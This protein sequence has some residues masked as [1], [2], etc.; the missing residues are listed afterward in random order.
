MR[1]IASHLSHIEARQQASSAGR[2]VHFISLA[3]HLMFLTEQLIFVEYHLEKSACSTVESPY[4]MWYGQ[5]SVQYS[6][7]HVIASQCTGLRSMYRNSSYPLYRLKEQ[8][9]HR[10]SFTSHR[11][12]AVSRVAHFIVLCRIVC[13]L[14]HSTWP[15]MSDIICSRRSHVTTV[16]VR[17]RGRQCRP[18]G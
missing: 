17:G 5:S 10:I 4:V 11:S 6:Q 18:D 14:Y 7:H 15:L 1:C 12:K 3:S 13:M 2:T 16:I 8:T 9:A